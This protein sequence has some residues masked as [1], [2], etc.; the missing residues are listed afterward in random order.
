[1]NIYIQQIHSLCLQNKYTNWYVKI[2]ENA[3]NRQEIIGYS[4]THHILP[5]CFRLGGDHDL[6]NLVDLTA[7]EHFICHM[8]LVKMVGDNQMK[9]KLAYAN[10]QMTMRSNGR[11]RYKICAQQY[12]FLRKQLSKFTKGL[13]KTEEAKQKMRKPRTTT[14][15]MRKP[16][17]VPNWN[18]GGTISDE[19]KL[20]QS[21]AMRGKLVGEKNGFY[22]KTHS[23]ETKQ[24]LR[25]LNAGKQLS[26]EHRQ[27]ISNAQKGKPTWNKGKPATDE[28]RKN[29]S[30]GL[31]GQ[32]FI[33]NGVENK[34][35]WPKDLENYDLTVWYRGKTTAPIP[36]LAGQIFI[37]NGIDNKRINPEDFITFD[38]TLWRRGQTRKRRQ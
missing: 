27:N 2:I 23:D 11:D 19:Q 16:K 15:N 28:H 13:P 10:W 12:E 14:V 24:H 38:Q 36:K 25:E 22:G 8:L 9:S 3:I 7:K 31:T 34:R 30:A 32:I 20:K 29:V 26:D 1:M 35:I 17:S 21:I 4:E 37:T 33:T 6:E 5:K 18:K